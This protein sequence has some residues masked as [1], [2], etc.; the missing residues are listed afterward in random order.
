MN[1]IGLTGFAGSGK[2]TVANYLVEA[3]GFT[4]LSFAAALKKMLR[5]LDP[6]LSAK[7]LVGTTFGDPDFTISPIRLSDLTKRGWREQEI[8]DSQ[9]GDE[10][11]RLLQVLGTDCIRAVDPEFWV[12]AAVAQMTDEDGKYVFDDVRFPNE[13]A[14]IKG[15]GPEGLWN[16]HRQ[17]YEAVNG[18]ASEQHAGEMGE[19]FIITNDRTVEMLHKDIDSALAIAFEGLKA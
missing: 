14:V 1:V 5:T 9:H 13:A 2:S 10:Y 11:R 18:H 15:Y 17:G 8:K 7:V 16:I 6:I 3:H 19:D 4:R 12:N